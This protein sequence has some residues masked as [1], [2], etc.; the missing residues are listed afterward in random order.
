MRTG[1]KRSTIPHRLKTEVAELASRTLPAESTFRFSNMDQFPSARIREI[2]PGERC[3]IIPHKLYSSLHIPIKRLDPSAIIPTR[4]HP[5]DA[6][7][8]LYALESGYLLPGQRA[9]VRTGIAVSIPEGYYGRVAPRSGL[10][11]KSGVDVLAGV[12][13]SGYH[14]EIKVVLINLS[15]GDECEVFQWEAGAKIAQIIIEKCHDVTWNEVDSLDGTE[16][17]ANGFGSSG[18]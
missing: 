15:D 11:V 12:L 7:A 4:A 18:I 10:A 9:A 8:D 17:G 2:K 6:G 3:K 5:T 13:D 14:G 16:R 1:W